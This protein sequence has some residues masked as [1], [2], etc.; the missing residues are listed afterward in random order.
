MTE[1]EFKLIEVAFRRGFW[2]GWSYTDGDG[3]RCEYVD[4]AWREFL[5]EVATGKFE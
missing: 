2:R 3:F 5:E 4:S 1:K